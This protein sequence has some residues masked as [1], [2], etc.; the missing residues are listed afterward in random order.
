MRPHESMKS[1]SLVV[2]ERKWEMIEEECIE[3]DRG[4]KFTFAWE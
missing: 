1:G 3:V 4:V 2:D